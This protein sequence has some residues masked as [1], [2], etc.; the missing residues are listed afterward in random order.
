MSTPSHSI[1]R[2]RILLFAIGSLLWGVILIGGVVMWVKRDAAH[3]PPQRDTSAAS[4]TAAVAPETTPAEPTW[5]PNGIE[6]FSLTE[7]SGRTITKADLLG[8]PWIVSFIF[9]NC[10]GPC[11]MVTA[12][13]YHLQKQLQ[14]T[15]VR[16]VTITVDPKRDTVEA[17]KKYAD[18]YK[19]DPDRW[20][21]LTGDQ[22]AIYRLIGKSFQMPVKEI[23]GPDRTPGWEIMHTTNVLLVDA[24][25]RVK[26]K[27]GATNGPA[28]A[29]LRRELNLKDEP[30]PEAEAT[31]PADS[32]ATQPPADASKP[33][34]SESR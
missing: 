11:P 14:D 12:Q 31:K 23:T 27:Y 5:D 30:A 6:D 16:L 3:N 8:R 10:A 9:I 1:P 32:T 2:S 22:D 26:G 4:T 7:R 18:Q 19:A 29:K 20:L 13:M 21:F 34:E 24:E 15:D 28:M 33:S 17:L 25:G